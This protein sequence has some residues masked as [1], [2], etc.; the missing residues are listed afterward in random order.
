MAAA[1]S[2]RRSMGCVAA[3]RSTSIQNA[4]PTLE[5]AEAAGLRHR[6]AATG[7]DVSVAILPADAQHELPNADAVLNEIVAGIGLEGTYAVVVG[8]QF[9]AASTELGHARAAELA[10]RASEE[11]GNER[12]ASTL[13]ALVD[14]VA[15]ETDGGG[16]GLSTTA[17]LALVPVLAGIALLATLV[18]ARRR[19][20][21]G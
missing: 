11:T 3:I 20:S 18:R 17:V 13:I 7:A 21:V 10:Q 2:R 9:R 15:Q 1:S 8:G 4:I 6:L 5:P 16:S 14:D 12:L 19:S